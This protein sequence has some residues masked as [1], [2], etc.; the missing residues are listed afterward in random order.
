ME[1]KYPLTRDEGQVHHMTEYDE[2]YSNAS[3][4]VESFNAFHQG[5]EMNSVCVSVNMM[6]FT[7]GQAGECLENY[8]YSWFFI[9]SIF[10]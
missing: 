3:G 8:L 5:I 10:I 4:N 6:L 2:D 1:C 7:C 9:K